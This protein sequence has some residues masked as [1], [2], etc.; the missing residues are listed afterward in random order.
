MPSKVILHPQLGVGHCQNLIPQFWFL[1]SSDTHKHGVWGQRS[2]E[3]A[4][5]DKEAGRNLSV[6]AREK[7][8]NAADAVGGVKHD[9]GKQS[10]S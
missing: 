1:H 4:R 9:E 8:A 5:K 3:M 10:Q 2:K 7:R 6:E